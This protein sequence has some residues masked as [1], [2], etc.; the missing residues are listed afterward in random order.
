MITWVSVISWS[1]SEYRLIF[2]HKGLPG[3]PS[4]SEY[5]LIFQHK[6]LPGLPSKPGCWPKWSCSPRTTSTTLGRNRPEKISNLRAMMQSKK[7]KCLKPGLSQDLDPNLVQQMYI[8][9]LDVTPDCF[10]ILSEGPNLCWFFFLKKVLES[11]IN[12]YNLVCRG[13]PFGRGQG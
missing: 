13:P 12:G 8:L 11:N 4:K 5:R 2:Q 10:D 6:G 9:L 3:L 1:L 7:T